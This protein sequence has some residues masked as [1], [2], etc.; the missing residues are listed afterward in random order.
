MLEYSDFTYLELQ[1]SGSTQIIKLFQEYIPDKVLSH[2]KHYAV[3]HAKPGHLYV[4]SVRN[5]IELYLSL[6]KYGLDQRGNFHRFMKTEGCGHYYSGDYDG[7]RDWMFKIYEKPSAGSGVQLEGYSNEYLEKFNL[8]L[9]SY[10]LYKLSTNRFRRVL[11]NSGDLSDLKSQAE[12]N[13]LVNFVIRNEYLE[14]DFVRFLEV[15]SSPVF[16]NPVELSKPVH[17]IRSEITQY[18]RMNKSLSGISGIEELKNDTELLHHV[19]NN[20]W[21]FNEFG[22]QDGFL[23]RQGQADLAIPE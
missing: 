10:R 5:P 11:K 14:I 15:V 18:G 22:Y 21:F 9:F 19:R 6:Y 2:T 23:A 16:S 17:E 12:D 4:I 8:G 7:F 3:R 13:R 20:E 1:K